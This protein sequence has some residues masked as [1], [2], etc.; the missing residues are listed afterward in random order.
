MQ[1]LENTVRDYAWGSPTGIPEMIGRTPDGTPAA[2]LWMGA[3]P[4]APSRAGGSPLD[5]LIAADP[6]R[7][8]GSESLAA[9]GERLPY[10]LKL[11]S[12]EIPLSVQVHPTRAQAQA[13]FAAEEAAGIPVDAPERNYRDAWHK[14]ELVYALTDFG[15]LC[16]LR[17]RTAVR[18][19]LERCASAELD[20]DCRASL[21]ALIAALESG[22]EAE[23]FAGAVALALRER[24]R[25]AALA[26]A[27][28]AAE[29][30]APAADDASLAGSGTDPVETLRIVHRDFPSDPGCIVALM[31]HRFTLRPGEALALNPGVLHAYLGGFAVE[32]MASSDNVLRGG[33]TSKHIDVDELLAVADFEPGLPARTAP[34]AAGE[35]SGERDDFALTVCCDGE[36]TVSRPGALIALC[37]DGTARLIAGDE[38]LV[39]DKGQSAL[40]RADEPRPIVR[41]EGCAVV[42]S[43][44][45]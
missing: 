30:P 32:V 11:L 3:H 44:R 36:R 19:A 17:S 31:L 26:D 33:L 34:N 6:A 28:A 1:L 45:L 38:E 39:L 37:T 22:E 5:E 12:A 2:E 27:L 35:L 29:I 40:I 20:D 43:A 41:A 15:A 7:F 14:P 24:A 42:A 13:G 18:A 23:G 16:G 4:S 9:F 8:L 25:F 10:L 21:S